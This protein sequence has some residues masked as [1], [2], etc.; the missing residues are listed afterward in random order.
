MNA[1][2]DLQAN[3]K[4][5]RFLEEAK[6]QSEMVLDSLP[7]VF[8]VIDKNGVI[9]RGNATLASYFNTPFE[10]IAGH[11]FKQLLS[12]TSWKN[13][14]NHLTRSKSQSEAGVD[15]E[16]NLVDQNKES[17][18]YLLNIRSIN[19]PD[20]KS[21]DLGLYVVT[22]SDITD[23]KKVTEKMSRM[24]FELQTAKAVQDTLFP[25]PSEFTSQKISLA[26][27]YQP[28][29]ECGGDW[30]F[31][32]TIGK[33]VF[34]WIGDVTG[35]G[36][37]AALVTSAARAAV[38]GLEMNEKMT[39][40]MALKILNKAVFDASKGQKYM[41]FCVVSIDLK[42]GECTY[43]T[44]AHELPFWIRNRKDNTIEDYEVLSLPTE[45]NTCLLGQEQETEFFEDTVT[46][47]PGDRLFL[48]TDGV[49]E[50][51]N[52]E[53]QLWGERKVRQ[54]IL[55]CARETDNATKF[56]YKFNQRLS[57]YRNKTELNDDMTYFVFNLRNYDSNAPKLK[58]Q[59]IITGSI[60]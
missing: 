26:G 55:A 35:H 53:Q 21:T 31:Y 28:A 48:Y 59:Q 6:A 49:T 25:E 5:I 43:S 1:N 38:S 14:S 34:L 33:K 12:D 16:M 8:A 57:E 60:P 42:N 30:W 27:S 29:S 18:S 11:L 2:K 7:G 45:H 3:H 23:V 24:E 41:S 51:A 39:P 10:S 47:L 58:T 54:A 13:F 22:G 20:Y 52:E 36:V 17:F 9:Y 50:L 4:I 32:N 46:L 40:A 44:A 19:N 37:S 15:F 56:V